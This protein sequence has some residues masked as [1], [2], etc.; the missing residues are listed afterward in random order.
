MVKIKDYKGKHIHFIGIG[1]SSMSGLAHLLSL[2]GYEVSGS[3][4]DQSHKTDKLAEE[5]IKVFIGHS[6]SNIDEADLIVYSAAIPESNVERAEAFKR[7]VPQIERCDLL[8]QLMEKQYAICVSG[9]HGK[10]TTTSMISKIFLDAGADPSI[11]IGG[12]L[13]LIG[14]STR[15]GNGDYFIAEACEYHHSFLHFKPN[16]EVLLNIDEDHLEYFG[17]ID[18]IEKAFGDYTQILPADGIIV[19]NGEDERVLRVM[20]GSNRAFIAFG[21]GGGFDVQ[22]ANIEYDVRGRGSFDLFAGGAFVSRVYV[23]IPGEANLMDA[24]ASLACAHACGLDLAAA[25]ESLSAFVGPHRRNEHTADIDG[26]ALYTDYGHNPAEIKS[27]LAIAAK[28]PH[29]RLI[30]VWQPHTYSRTKNL[31]DGFVE[32]FD[33]VDI[34]LITDIM[35]ARETDPGDIHSSMFIEPLKKRG[36]TAV[37][38]PTFDDAEAF[39]RSYWQKGDL[40]ISHGCGNIDLLNEQIALHGDTV[41]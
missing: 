17:S 23:G 35:G 39:L 9:T 14:G 19:G 26:V 31:F 6:P 20:K 7:D 30:S 8:G 21:R 27:A 22:A 16:L 32:T 37:Y 36:V 40:M 5:G 33:N 11:H 18:N 28:A 25:S 12:E 41:K 38:T 13:D 29:K 2:L 3:D 4:R 1:G 34:L 15:Y 10:T 24:L